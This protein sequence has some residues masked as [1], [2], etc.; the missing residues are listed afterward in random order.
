LEALQDAE[1]RFGENFA[2]AFR[3]V[4]QSDENPVVYTQLEEHITNLEQTEAMI[5]YLLENPETQE[6][7]SG[8][9]LDELETHKKT[10]T[11]TKTKISGFKK[12]KSLK[13]KTKPSKTSL[14]KSRS[15]EPSSAQS[16]AAATHEEDIIREMEETEAVRHLHRQENVHELEDDLHDTE[17]ADQDIDPSPE[18]GQL[19]TL[20][21]YKARLH[22]NISF[23][24]SYLG[25]LEETKRHLQLAIE[26]DPHCTSDY[27]VTE[28]QMM[29][30]RAMEEGEDDHELE[31]GAISTTSRT[32]SST[33]TGSRSHEEVEDADEVPDLYDMDDEPP[34]MAKKR[35]K[36]TK[37]K[38]I[39]PPI[40]KEPVTSNSIRKASR[41]KLYTPEG[42]M[43]QLDAL[44]HPKDGSKPTEATAT[45]LQ[46]LEECKEKA[47][48]IDMQALEKQL[49]GTP[50]TMSKAVRTAKSR[51]RKDLKYSISASKRAKSAGFD[52]GFDSAL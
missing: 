16:T 20:L 51:R 52:D 2:E 50:R 6:R 7:S 42:M 12:K 14:K 10:K 18:D 43:T 41:V 1:Q 26:S 46:F 36:K 27:I 15:S 5:R 48:N 30:K 35:T 49:A 13:K 24:M 28:E 32:L 40:R 33:R 34:E 45:L 23:C 29:Q 47:A 21:T 11:K 9:D 37:Q 4:Q 8:A 19:E 22:Y 17:L 44:L 31:E 39:I 25:E 38:F 3:H